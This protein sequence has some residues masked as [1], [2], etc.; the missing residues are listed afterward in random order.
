MPKSWVDSTI[1]SIDFETS[2]GKI[3]SIP[4]LAYTNGKLDESLKKWLACVQNSFK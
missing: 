4:V 3:P 1:N 2:G